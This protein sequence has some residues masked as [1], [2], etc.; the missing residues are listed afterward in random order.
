MTAA[1]IRRE[2]MVRWT[3]QNPVEIRFG[4]G[5]IDEI[6]SIL[7]GR[8]YALVTHSNNVLEPWIARIRRWCA[9]PVLTLDGVDSHPS[10]TTLCGLAAR[11]EQCAT[12]PELIVA[13]G[14]GSVIDSAKFVAAG[15]GTCEEV[16]RHMLEGTPLGELADP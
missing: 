4:E 15:R 1:H 10:L 14:G 9:P 12:Q 2:T 13:M 7:Q 8:R 11:L 5:R 3:F 16:T 6:G